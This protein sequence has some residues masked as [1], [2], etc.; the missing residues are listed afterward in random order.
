MEAWA[1]R[2]RD[3][4]RRQRAEL[5]ARA[6][7]SHRVTLVHWDDVEGF[8]V[9]ERVQPLGGR[10]QRLARR[11]GQRPRRR[12]ARRARARA[13]DH[14]AARAQRRG[15]DLPRAR[16]LG[17]AVAGRRDV[18][19]RARATRSSTR[20]AAPAHTLIAGDDGL[21]V[22]VFGTRLTPESGVL[23]R[24]HVAWL[25]DRPS[26]C[27]RRIP[28]DAEAA[29]GIPE[30]RAGRAAAERR[31]A[32]RRRGR[33][34]RHRRSGSAPRAAREAERPQLGRRCRRTTKARRR[35]ATPPRRRSSSILDG[36]GTLE[37]WGPPK[38]GRAAAD[39]ARTRRIRSRRGHVVA[40][41][42]GTRISHCL[43]RRPQGAH[44]PRVRHE[45]PERRLLLPALEQDL[46]PRARPDRPA[47][48]ARLLR[49]RARLELA[50]LPRSEAVVRTRSS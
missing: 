25:A 49:R 44:L 3:P 8:D 12:A 34:R 24:T 45:R 26:R 21:E 29:L 17:D 11:G 35:T 20:P 37:L 27:S 43:P 15:G 33:L 22:L 31:R 42:A 48:A 40:R 32:R 4:E 16:R 50:G 41:P 5:L 39:R 23:P 13:D 38:P 36:E 19:R 2:E 47:R 14:A 1:R 9:P 46:L 30:R 18:R 7:D 6:C 28:W 10:W